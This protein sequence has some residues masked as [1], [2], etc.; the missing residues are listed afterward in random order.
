ML[1]NFAQCPNKEIASDNLRIGSKD[2]EGFIKATGFGK[3][4]WDGSEMSAGRLAA[5]F[6]RAADF[7]L[8]GIQ[9]I[10]VCLMKYSED[11]VA[12]IKAWSFNRCA[13]TGRVAF[14]NVY[15]FNPVW[16]AVILN[17][18]PF[19]ERESPTVKLAFGYTENKDL[20][21]CFGGHILGLAITVLP[22]SDAYSL[23]SGYRVIARKELSGIFDIHVNNLLK[24]IVKTT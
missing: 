18:Y 11:E 5:A 22:A 16:T 13:S 17:G 20:L 4:E 12:L 19:L 15:L 9:F 8:I 21:S 3:S 10:R 1:V 23:I 6:H 7:K 14:K 24:M 2:H